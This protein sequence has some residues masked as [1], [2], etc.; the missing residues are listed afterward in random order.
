MKKTIVFYWYFCKNLLPV[1]T[2]P[3]NST[4]KVT[5]TLAFAS[6]WTGEQKFKISQLLPGS[7]KYSIFVSKSE[8][9]LNKLYLPNLDLLVD[10][11]ALKPNVGAREVESFE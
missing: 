6:V 11:H 3:E 1:D 9:P 2:C 7:A 4:T 10:T 5:P 8:T